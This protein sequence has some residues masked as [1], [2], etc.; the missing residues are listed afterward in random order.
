MRE[1]VGILLKDADFVHWSCLISRPDHL[2]YLWYLEKNPT[3]VLPIAATT[4][5]LE[6]RTNPLGITSK[7]LF[8]QEDPGHFL[9]F[10]END[11]GLPGEYLHRYEA[12]FKHLS[13]GV[14]MRPQHSAVDFGGRQ[15]LLSIPTL[16]ALLRV[17]FPLKIL[18]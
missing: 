14:R 18:D 8:F 15:V 2:W 17:G 6:S 7:I 5:P 1:S 10:Q 4:N 13:S 11:Q 12:I 16:L 3:T 9:G